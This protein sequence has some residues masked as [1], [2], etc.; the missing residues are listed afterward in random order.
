[1]RGVIANSSNIGAALLTRQL[2]KETLHDY[3][4]SFGLGSPTGIELPG[5]SRGIVPPADMTDGQRDQVAFGQAL[6]VT[7]HPGG[8]GGRGT[9]STAASTTHRRC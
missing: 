7:G 4:V 3:L 9:S 6:S 2:S 1:M 8:G 5:E